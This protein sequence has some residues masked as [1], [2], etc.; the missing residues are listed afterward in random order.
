MVH[1]PVF[2]SFSE[3]WYYAK[4]LSREQR[5]IIFKSLPNDEKEFLDNSYLEDGWSDLFYRNEIDEK[6][7]EL[8]EAYGYNILEIR[9]KVLRGKSVYV[10]LKFW[11]IVEE[12]M[13]AY[14]PEVVAFVMSGMKAIPCD[15]NR[16]VCLVVHSKYYSS[17]NEKEN[18]LD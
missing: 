13:G 4:Y 12:Q 10:P 2:D 5:K 9:A 14:K 16:D 8:K 15:E 7:D 1:K 3:Y 18:E 17:D 11:K 6:I